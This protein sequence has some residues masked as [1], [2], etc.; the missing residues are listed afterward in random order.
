MYANADIGAPACAALDDS[1]VTDGTLR[2]T[3]MVSAAP[4]ALRA[5]TTAQTMPEMTPYNA[6]N[7]TNADEG[8]DTTAY[9]SVATADAADATQTIV[10]TRSVVGRSVVVRWTFVS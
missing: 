1:G 4:L 6:T 9:V 3:P 7:A 2:A 10:D 8:V 5:A